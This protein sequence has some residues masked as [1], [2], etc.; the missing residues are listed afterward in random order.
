MRVSS[1]SGIIPYKR[2][3]D[4]IQ[5][6]RVKEQMKIS[7][8]NKIQE[9]SDAPKDIVDVK[10]IQNRIDSNDKY[11][12]ILTETSSEILTAEGKLQNISDNLT[13]IRQLAI[14]ATM[15]GSTGNIKSLAV[16][17]KGLIDDVMVS[18]NGDHNG[19]FLF[20]GTKTTENSL[21]KTPGALKSVPFEY[22]EGE[23]TADNPSGLSVVFKGN[24]EDRIINKDKYSQEIIN[25][26]ADKLFGG[27]GT[28]MFQD[29]IDMY[30]VLAYN[31]DGSDRET[32]D[33]FTRE[34]VGKL[35]Q[36]QNKLADYI[37]I[38]DVRT[39]ESGSIVAR[40]DAITSQMKNENTLYKDLLSLKSDTDIAEATIELSK[41]EN[42]LNYSLQ[43][44]SRIISNS[45]FDFLR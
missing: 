25:Q 26:T 18:A 34:D 39:G 1:N 43:A 7:T 38:A 30:N 40:F 33:L 32:N 42:A 19:K 36:I 45:L 31:T 17:V 29:L 21:E 16:Y 14:D 9:L 22:V 11:I 10:L 15:T 5:S 12:K 41:Q 24:F 8:G 4:N 20:S 27:D 13:R 2:N 35:N 44:G 37:E 3:L 28:Q 6:K 23:S